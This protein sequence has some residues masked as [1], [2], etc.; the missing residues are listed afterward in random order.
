VN[1]AFDLLLGGDGSGQ[2]GRPLSALMLLLRGVWEYLHT[3]GI[4]R[5]LGKPLKLL[6]ALRS[7]LLVSVS[8]GGGGLSVCLSVCLG[9]PQSKS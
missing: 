8:A 2:P 4:G 3:F 9:W 7:V 5:V 1:A 6:H